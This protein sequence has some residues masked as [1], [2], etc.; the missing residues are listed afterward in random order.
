MKNLLKGL[1]LLNVA[2]MM[3]LTACNNESSSLV[4]PEQVE[5]RAITASG[6]VTESATWSGTVYL[7]GKVYVT[8][9]ATLTIMPGTKVI[10]KYTNDPK[11]AS[12]LIITRGSKIEANGTADNPIIMTSEDSHKHPG[13]WGGLVLMGR[14]KINQ[15]EATIEGITK[16]EAK[17]ADIEYG[18]SDDAD[19]SGSLTY[20]RVEYA[21][22]NIADGNELNSF[23]FGGVGSG[24]TL[25][26]LQSYYG[27]DDGFEFFGGTV[28]AK[29][30]VSTSTHDDAFDFDF[31]YRGTIEYA[32]STVDPKSTFYTKDPNGIECDND[33]KGSSLTPLTRP[34]L[35]Y[36]TIVGT[37]TGKV[38]KSAVEKGEPN[39][40]KSGANFRRNAQFDLQNSII[41]GYPIGI[42]KDT[43]N[44]YIL[45]NN[46]VTSQPE[47]KEFV[48]FTPDA[49]NRK[50][51][52]LIAP[53][54]GTGKG[55]L[56]SKPNVG[57]FA[58]GYWLSG[59]W[60]IG[61]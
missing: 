41:C 33:G 57:A 23:T 38:A 34:V 1:L 27:E 10:G 56:S 15:T 5:T 45:K 35:K 39:S 12:A 31:G 42:L 25:H 11:E 19:S 6:K 16:E 13:G 44:D 3:G 61:Y 7:Q 53:F 48:P 30:L 54:S 52:P 60:V 55:L 4:A 17:G 28:S 43:Q 46:Y 18:G 32:L 8:N 2:L 36:F 37:S 58:H 20:V 14:A 59:N 21:G 47:G 40:L 24:T 50:E 26:H 51:L 9:G 29:Y 22:A 49:S